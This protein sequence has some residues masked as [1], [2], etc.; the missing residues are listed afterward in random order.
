MI[1]LRNNAEV[2]S[3]GAYSIHLDQNAEVDYEESELINLN[4]SAG[5]GGNWQIKR[6]NWL[7][8]TL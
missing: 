6:G 3:L 2:K 8:L 1:R 5:P 7:D 4:F